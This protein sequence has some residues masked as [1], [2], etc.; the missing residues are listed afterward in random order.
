MSDFTPEITWE[1]IL[2]TTF[3]GNGTAWFRDPGE[4]R[5]NDVT[6]PEAA[7]GF[8][9]Q[10]P[11]S[12]FPDTRG[13]S[14]YFIHAR[15]VD[16]K[17][18]PG[19]SRQFD[20]VKSKPISESRLAPRIEQ[21][22]ENIGLSVFRFPVGEGAQELVGYWNNEYGFPFVQYGQIWETSDGV[23]YLAWFTDIFLN[24]K[25][26]SDCPADSWA[27]KIPALVEAMMYLAEA[28]LKQ[29]LLT[30]SRSVSSA[31]EGVAEKRIPHPGIAF[32]EGGYAMVVRKYDDEQISLAE[33]TCPTTISACYD[34]SEELNDEEL[35]ITI[36]TLSNAF[37]SLSSQ[38]VTAWDAQR[39]ADET[40]IMTLS[41]AAGIAAWEDLPDGW[42]DLP[43]GES[44]YVLNA[45]GLF[46]PACG[47]ESLS[48]HFK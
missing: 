29:S 27:L 30:M 47:W 40:G 6:A 23:E 26:L 12:D 7:E 39:H 5:E 42:E 11:E 16:G 18:F 4:P 35:E 31:F 44:V 43:D 36:E 34:I 46:I 19:W 45:N 32:N 15:E 48:K 38:T 13:Y 33:F 1:M 10:L 21:A 20:Y 3:M 14:K 2:K 25:K 24:T 37:I 9:F 41:E 22:F 28:P 8:G 17:P